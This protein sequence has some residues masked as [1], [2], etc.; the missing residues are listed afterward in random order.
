MFKLLTLFTKPNNTDK[1]QSIFECNFHTSYV[2]PAQP[3]CGVGNFS[4]IWATRRQHEI[5][6]TKLRMIKYKDN[7]NFACVFAY[8]S[9]AI[10]I[11]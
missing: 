6:Y 10:K 4:K 9:C 5:Q 3:L 7:Y 2:R 8:K 11:Y 1:M